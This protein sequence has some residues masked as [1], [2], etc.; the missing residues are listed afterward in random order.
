MAK[1]KTAQK[2][3]KK[4]V[5]V[6]IPYKIT[7][8]PLT[9]YNVVNLN[10]EVVSTHKKMWDAIYYL[11]VIFLIISLSTTSVKRWC[12]MVMCSTNS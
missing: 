11:L 7:G 5:K 6:V 4:E 12:P 8:G 1:G 10:D 3:A 2:W 9:G